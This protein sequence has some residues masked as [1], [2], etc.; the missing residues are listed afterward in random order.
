[1]CTI[2]SHTGLYLGIMLSITAYQYNKKL[3]SFV[4]NFR[5][6]ALT[7]MM[8]AQAGCMK[9]VKEQVLSPVTLSKHI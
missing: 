7:K 6:G 9:G 8:K 1:M 5:P 2:V 3:Y 4:I